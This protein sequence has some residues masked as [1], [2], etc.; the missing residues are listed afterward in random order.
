MED[1]EHHGSLQIGDAVEP[2]LWPLAQYHCQATR[3]D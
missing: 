3:V 1:G 2:A